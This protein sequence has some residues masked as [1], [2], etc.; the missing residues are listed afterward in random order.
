MTGLDVW[1][2]SAQ[3]VDQERGTVPST[4]AEVGWALMGLAASRH[5]GHP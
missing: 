4:A 2:L 3:Q 5:S 1:T